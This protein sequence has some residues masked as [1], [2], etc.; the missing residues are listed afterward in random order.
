MRAISS[1][2]VP[3]FHKWKKS[4]TSPTLSQAVSDRQ[5]QLLIESIERREGDR[6]E[7]KADVVLLADLGQHGQV[8]GRQPPHF[9][10]R[11]ARQSLDT[12][13]FGSSGPVSS[14]TIGQPIFSAITQRALHSPNRAS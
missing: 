2:F 3:L 8:L 1:G 5:L 11:L 9:G 13:P 6:F 14:C 10:P 4:S 7:I 12:A